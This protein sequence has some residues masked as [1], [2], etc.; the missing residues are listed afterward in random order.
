MKTTLLLALGCMLLPLAGQETPVPEPLFFEVGFSRTGGACSEMMGGANR[1]ASDVGLGYTVYSKPGIG[2]GGASLALKIRGLET[3][4]GSH[5]EVR[6]V[7]FGPEVTLKLGSR[8]TGA[9]LRVGYLYSTW[10]ATSRVA[11]TVQNQ[12]MNRM[13]AEFGV[14]WQFEGRWSL[15]LRTLSANRD[16]ESAFTAVGAAV[17]VRF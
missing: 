15:E 17:R 6:M 12:D 7:G 9:F 3:A 16:S 5:Q 10:S 4:T 8:P 13:T 14:G 11:G 1:W 2:F